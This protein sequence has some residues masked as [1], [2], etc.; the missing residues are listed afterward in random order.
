MA[1]RGKDSINFLGRRTMTE[2]YDRDKKNFLLWY[3]YAT[4]A[5]IE[6][7]MSINKKRYE[8]LLA[9]YKDEVETIIKYRHLLTKE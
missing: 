7:A 5:D 3:T 6:K 4:E 1:G 2:R 8:E 9:R